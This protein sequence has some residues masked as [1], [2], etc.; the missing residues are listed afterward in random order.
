[1]TEKQE[2]A[3]RYAVMKKLGCDELAAAEYIAKR[4]VADRQSSH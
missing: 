1:M 4:L 3:E 2:K